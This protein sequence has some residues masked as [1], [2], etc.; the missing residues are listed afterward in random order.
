MMLNELQAV[1]KTENQIG[2]PKMQEDDFKEVQSWKWKATEKVAHT[3]K[4]AVPATT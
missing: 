4:K 1:L 3:M 2:Q